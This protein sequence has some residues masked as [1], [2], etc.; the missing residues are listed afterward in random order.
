LVRGVEVG[1]NSLD[2][3]SGGG[4]SLFEGGFLVFGEGSRDSSLSFE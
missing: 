2:P 1:K 3:F 4:L